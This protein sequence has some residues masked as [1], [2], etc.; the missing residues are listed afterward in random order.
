L[1]YEAD[2]FISTIPARRAI[3]LMMGLSQPTFHRNAIGIVL[4]VKA[5]DGMASPSPAN[6]EMI[7]FSPLQARIE[8]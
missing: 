6:A 2:K 8:V 7:C 5:P 1:P 3:A 4:S